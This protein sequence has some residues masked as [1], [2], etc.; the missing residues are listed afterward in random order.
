MAAR[1]GVQQLTGNSV[2]LGMGYNLTS[3]EWLEPW[4]CGVPCENRQ[5]CGLPTPLS[6]VCTAPWYGELCEA[7]CTAEVNCSGHGRCN[8]TDGSC[9]CS[10]VDFYGVGCSQQRE[11]QGACCWVR[12]LLITVGMRQL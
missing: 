4:F 10:E 11:G 6:C 12:A 5:S 8:G 2:A 9:V 3:V 7:I 1:E